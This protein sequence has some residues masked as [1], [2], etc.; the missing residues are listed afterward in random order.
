MSAGDLSRFDQLVS[1]YLDDE[2]TPSEAPEL[3]SLLAEPEFAARFLEIMRLNAEIAGLLA[4]PVPD[5]AMVELVGADIEKSLAAAPRTGG[6]PLRIVEQ[7]A[8][9]PSTTAASPVVH[10]PP[11]K[12]GK[13][14]SRL[15]WAAMFIV[16]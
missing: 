8:A 16:F 15:A 13:A 3:V 5:A 2:L 10:P 1:R 11:R 14:L 6:G 7:P 12:R 4:A 9:T